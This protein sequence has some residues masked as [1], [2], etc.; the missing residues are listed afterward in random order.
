MPTIE[1]SKRDLEG[2]TGRKFTK[3]QLEEGLLFAKSELESLQGDAMKIEVKDTNRPDLWSLEGI[4][5]ELRARIGKEKGLPKFKV[6]KGKVK[7][8]IEKGVKKSRPLMVAAVVR[9]VKVSEDF[10]VQMVQLQEKVGL[11]Y[12]RRRKE[13]GI[14][15]YDFDKL[16]PPIYYKGYKKREV[17]F[18]PLDFENEMFLDDILELHPKGK[19]YG[20]LISAYEYYPIVIDSAG[21]VASMPPIIN[22]NYTGK[23]TEKTR[24]LFIEI[25]GWNEEYVNVALNVIVAALAER[26][27]KVEQVQ[28]VDGRKKFWTPEFKEKEIA[29]EEELF[30]R[31]S[32]EK[33][34]R[35]E[36]VKL[37]E[38]ARYKV[39]GKGKKLL[40]SYPAYRQDI[41]H[42]VDVVEDAIISFGY[43]KFVPEEVKMP[44]RGCEREETVLQEKVR[45]V[46]VGMG[47][48]E[49]M[50]FTL[51][52]KE[53]QEGKMLLKGEGFVELANPMSA[54]WAI[55]RKS[56]VPE[57]LA[58]FGR[59][60]N[61]EYP[62]KIFEVGK[63]LE[64]DKRKET[65]VREPVKICIALSGRGFGFNEMK[66][67]LDA[68]CENMGWKHA[69]RKKECVSFKKG[70]CAEVKIGNKKGIIGEVSV[71]V[72]KNFGLEMPVSVIELEF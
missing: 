46:C 22:S 9:G 71:E 11:T 65:N 29:V 64:L 34:S 3:E 62:Q 51:S 17:K 23:V 12:G 2:L 33:W 68:L 21:V 37:L 43:N 20:H 19:E 70:F 58:F 60:K 27:G 44:V 30:R 53:K 57:V 18:A 5:R 39:Q 47:L 25:T 49:V 14:G 55:F 35:K 50:N 67:Y 61:A 10:L 72:L 7:L 6:K 1:G 24:N 63:T 59:N 54:E 28:V 15:L 48:Q 38:M 26:G 66:R 56:L 45:D 16:K 8:I 52:S 40:C 4:A 41:L 69:V 36:I 32:G 13:T 31:I 42:P